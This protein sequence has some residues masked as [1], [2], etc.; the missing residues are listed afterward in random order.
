MSYV[1]FDYKFAERLAVFPGGRLSNSAL[2]HL[3]NRCEI[4]IPIRREIGGTFLFCVRQ[5]LTQR[6]CSGDSTGNIF[7]GHAKHWCGFQYLRMS[8]RR[9]I[10]DVPQSRGGS[11]EIVFHAKGAG[12]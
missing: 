2:V 10:I 12:F 6:H 3:F 7:C 5:N 4:Y 8:R 9:R 1:L 11:F